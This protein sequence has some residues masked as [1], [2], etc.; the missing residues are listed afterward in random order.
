MRYLALVT[1]FDG[2]LAENDT[3]SASTESA[4]QRL[5]VSGRRVI[6]VT[7]RRLDDLLTACP[8][9]QLFDMIVAENGALLYIPASREV[10]LLAD[11]PPEALLQELKSLAIEPLEIGEVLIATHEPHRRAVQDVIWNLG[12]E[13]Q[14]IGNRGSVMLLPAGT[15][16][17]TGLQHALR[18]LGLSRHEIVGVGDAENDHSFLVQ[19]ECPVAVS[20]AASSIKEITAFATS[21]PNG[22]GVVELINELIASDLARMGGKLPQ[23][24]ITLGKGVDGASVSLAPY[25]HNVLVAGPSG[26]GKSTFTAGII[27]RLIAKDYQVCILDPEGD[28]GTIQ[29][30]VAIGNQRRTPSIDEILAILEDPAINI[31]INLLGT[32]LEDRPGF[33]AQLVPSLQ[34][35]RARTGRPHWI[36]VDEAHHLLPSTW[37]HAASVLP[38]R[39]HETILVTVHP[40]HVARDILRPIDVVVAVGPRPDETLTRFAQTTDQELAWPEDLVHKS[41]HVVTWTLADNR[42]PFA[43][44]TLPNRSE[45]LR[46]HRKYAEGNLRWHSFYFRGPTGS[47]NLRAQNLVVFC[48]I[49]E[50]IDEQTWTYHLRRGDYSRWFRHAIRDEYLAAEAERVERRADIDSW[51]T[52]EIICKLINARY[53][54]PE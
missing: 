21:A 41:G 1:D 51:Q 42:P 25:G 46:H 18:E 49:A 45:R 6:L 44:R 37:G 43:M 31:S 26:C 32:K 5:R 3:V 52:R 27:E 40:K 22:R 16:K 4:L 38:L 33:F 28:Y 30:I 39:L 2:T 13:V 20:N 47:H 17:G 24:W 15:N 35:M 29:N 7:G 8:R 53:S 19:C 54:L 48:Q 50:G 23:H 12:L 34:A 10:R 11:P 36:V 9:P 14:V